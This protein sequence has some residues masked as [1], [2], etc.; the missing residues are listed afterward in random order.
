[1]D[2]Y[3]NSQVFPGLA[4]SGSRLKKELKASRKKKWW[5]GQR[6]NSK[7][8]EFD[9]YGEQIGLTY[10]GESSYKTTSGAVVSS[11]VLLVMIAF[12]IKQLYVFVNKQDPTV[13]TQVYL[14][15]LNKADALVPQKY[16]YDIAFGLNKTLDPSIGYFTFNQVNFNY[17]AQPDGSV[18][19]IKSRIP[20]QF[21]PCGNDFFKGFN[22]TTIDMYSIPYMNCLNFTGYQLQGDYYSEIFSYMQLRLFK[23]KNSTKKGSTVC[24]DPEVIDSFFTSSTLSIPMVNSYVD[25]TDF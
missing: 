13:S 18:S 9:I 10:K 5:R 14:A 12:S 8:K 2:H 15:D 20:L 25:F 3:S 21:V 24:R 6:L 17:V 7:F 1:M 22:Q 4:R 23:C 16:G 19:R 11:V